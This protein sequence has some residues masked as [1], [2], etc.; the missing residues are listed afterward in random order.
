MKFALREN[1]LYFDYTC[2]KNWKASVNSMLGT[3]YLRPRQI[4]TI[5]DP[6]PSAFQQNAYEGDL[7]SL[8]IVTFWQSAHGD[9][10]P[11]QDMLTY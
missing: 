1:S 8:F 4:F 6:Y 2:K 7:L 10:P 11:P 3:I 5:F 9:T